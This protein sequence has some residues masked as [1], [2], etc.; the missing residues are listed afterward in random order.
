MQASTFMVVNQPFNQLKRIDNRQDKLR[1]KLLDIKGASIHHT[2]GWQNCDI[3][4]LPL[5]R[6]I[7]QRY[8]SLFSFR[9]T[10]HYI[11]IHF[12]SAGLYWYICQSATLVSFGRRPA[13]SKTGV[14]NV[15]RVCGEGR[16]Q[17]L[18]AAFPVSRLHTASLFLSNV[19][20]FFLALLLIF[21]LRWDA[22]SSI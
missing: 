3:W 14:M 6:D 11:S 21:S 22:R 1:T 17:W 4:G 16:L 5:Q 19:Q 8:E 15:L 10:K 12:R 18:I 13:A 20:K 2:Y 7:Y 9:F